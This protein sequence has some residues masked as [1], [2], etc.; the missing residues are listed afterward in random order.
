M[1]FTKFL[2]IHRKEKAQASLEY[3]ILFAIITLL[4][5][6]GLTKFL[7]N[8][9][10]GGIR[11]ATNAVFVEA[12]EKITEAD[13]GPLPRVGSALINCIGRIDTLDINTIGADLVACIQGA[14]EEVNI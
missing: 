8:G 4:T 10:G 12:A 2:K 14:L 13:Q 5:L 11:N 6:V 9:Q 1:T 7:D 3:F